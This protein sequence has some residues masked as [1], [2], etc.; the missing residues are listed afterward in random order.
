MVNYW[1]KNTSKGKEI[2]VTSDLATCGWNMW[3]V[4]FFLFLFIHLDT[5]Y[6]TILCEDML[7]KR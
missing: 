2:R 1:S 4:P 3:R 7:N 6:L 5:L